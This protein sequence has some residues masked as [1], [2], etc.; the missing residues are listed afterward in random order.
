MRNFNIVLSLILFMTFNFA[1]TST[2]EAIWPFKK[3]EKFEELK[4]VEEV[5]KELITKEKPEPKVLIPIED[6]VRDVIIEGNNIITKE[7]I[8]EIIQTK[9]GAEFSK[10]AVKED[11]KI[12]YKMGYFTKNIKA[13]P[14]KTDKGV[15]LKIVVSENVPITGFTIEGNTEVE[16]TEIL[17]IVNKHIGLPQNIVMLNNIINQIEN[18]YASKGYVLAR[19]KKV[20]DEPDGN[21]SVDIDEGIIEK[22][23]IKGNY[24][25]KE[26][27]ITRNM[28]MK[29]GDIY[30]ENNLRDDFKRIF[31]LQAFSDV[32]R[33]LSPGEI[34]P[35][36]YLLTVE[37]DEK[38]SG[39]ISIGGGF[40]T[41]TGMFGSTGF[42]DYNFRGLG[43][44]LGINFTTGSGI[45]F[46]NSNIMRRASYQLEAKF[47]EP[48]FKQ[49]KN[50]LLVTAFGRDYASWQVPLGIEKRVG[51]E[52][53]VMRPFDNHPHLSGGISLGIEGVSV[54]EGDAVGAQNMFSSAGI[55]FSKRAE[56]LVGGTFIS[57]GPKLI[58]DTR[59]NKFNPR[60]GIYSKIGIDENIAVGGGASSYGKLDGVIQKF[61]PVGKKSAF[62][63]SAKAGGGLNG[64]MPLF[65]QYGLGGIRSI[66]GYRQNEAGNGKGLLMGSA[67]FKTPIP[68]V[69]RFTN[70]DFLNGIRVVTFL[71]AGQVFGKNLVNELS[72]Y[73]GY[74]IS[75]GMGLR[76]YIP[77]L[78]PIKLDYGMPLTSL[79]TYNGIPRGK[80]GRF[81]FDIGEM[82]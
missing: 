16:D 17:K 7:E 51:T 44:H 33:T 61:Y 10:N 75:T 78:G 46:Q 22:I 64:N 71:D 9:K 3:K 31:G 2:A 11:L 43:Q 58:Y 15:I 21:V 42:T 14:K 30:N 40:D 54:K 25:T 38:R 57:L 47:F 18:L 24:K 65:A 69:D 13:I 63:L 26:F 34:D 76:I 62:S 52:V 19:V 36:K 53:Q 72:S 48:H 68:F 37:V 41:T 81:T 4:P 50:S 55:N 77:G 32:R 67:E 45:L 39:S 35:E 59:D 20:Y 70:S 73:P 6:Q 60:E 56:M 12:I 27:V 74:G 23:K 29:E 80:S 66:R 8:L 5:R 1:F 28:L 79:G 49:T 82:Y